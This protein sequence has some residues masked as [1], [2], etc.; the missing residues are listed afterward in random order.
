MLLAM[1]RTI[2]K[3]LLGLLLLTTVFAS[4]TSLTFFHQND[5][6]PITAEAAVG[7]YYNGISD[8]LTGTSLLSALRSLNSSERDRT[9][10]YGSMGSYYKQT[11]GDP[12]NSNNLIAFY[13]GTSAY[14]SGSFSGNFNREHVWPNSRGGSAVEGD[15][16]MTRP[17]LVA[18][19][20][21]RGNSFYVEGR[22][23]PR[24]V[25]PRS[26]ILGLDNT[27]ASP[28]ASFFYAVVASSSLSLVD[29]HDDPD[30]NTMGKLSTLLDWNL[31]NDIDATENQRN[32]APQS[33]PG[34]RNPFIDHPEYACKIWGD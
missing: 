6:E 4:G 19:N 31:R 2:S 3:S 1:S 7:T 18:E 16:H 24:R 9:V 17:T 25:G 29:T 8:S 32:E 23:V 12:A 14:F 15:I 21:S 33:I 11:D 13:S 26:R 10:G 5:Y 20:G 28:P 27:G 30:N 22:P 34:N